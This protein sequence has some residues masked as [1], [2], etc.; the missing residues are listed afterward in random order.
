MTSAELLRKL[1]KLARQRGIEVRVER[2]KG[3]HRKVSFGQSRT[4]IPMHGSELK[5]G[6][7]NGILRDL[8][9]KKE[10]L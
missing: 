6:T 1:Q 7:L 4:I 2:G 9:I 3:S 8:G 5:T 10:D